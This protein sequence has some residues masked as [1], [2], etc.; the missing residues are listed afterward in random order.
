VT[1]LLLIADPEVNI[2]AI[3]ESVKRFIQKNRGSLNL[4]QLGFASTPG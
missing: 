2:H 1:T 4:H 3:T